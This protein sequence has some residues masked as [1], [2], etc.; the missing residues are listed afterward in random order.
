MGVQ[1]VAQQV[2]LKTVLIITGALI[3]QGGA[4]VKFFQMQTAQ[5]MK[6][7]DLENK[8][9]EVKEKQTLQ[10]GYQIETEKNVI[11][12]DT[13]LDSIL[14]ALEDLKKQRC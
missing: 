8:V 2:D 1:V 9:K 7:S 12:I 4:V 5:N 11:R 3:I 14:S 6:I 13:K 10:T